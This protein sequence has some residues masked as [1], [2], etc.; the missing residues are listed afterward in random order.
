[1]N[2]ENGDQKRIESKLTEWMKKNTGGGERRTERGGRDGRKRVQRRTSVQKRDKENPQHRL[3]GSAGE[4]LVSK[5]RR[6]KRQ[7][8]EKKARVRR[9]RGR[10]RQPRSERSEGK[11]DQ[12]GGQSS[13]SQNDP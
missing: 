12:H 7:E 8:H 2:W 9:S 5:L 1:M 3:W 11:G 10:G 6:K 4:N 13:D